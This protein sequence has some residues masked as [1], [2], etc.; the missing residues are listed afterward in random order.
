[1]SA[2]SGKKSKPSWKQSGSDTG[3]E[4]QTLGEPST[5]GLLVLLGDACSREVR[6]AYRIFGRK[7]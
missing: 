2:S 3:K 1:V 5:A 7:T 4:D 6:N